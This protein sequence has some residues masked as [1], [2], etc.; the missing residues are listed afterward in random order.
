MNLLNASIR[1][2][3]EIFQ[4]LK[5]ETFNGII[6]I[7]VILLIV[8]YFGWQ[9]PFNKL[10]APQLKSQYN[11]HELKLLAQLFTT[12]SFWIFFILLPIIFLKITNSPRN[13]TFRLEGL[14]L[15][16]KKAWAP[17]ILF[18]IIMVMILA[19]ICS[20][21]SFYRFYPLFRP[22]SLKEWM[23]FEL[24][25][26]PQFIAVEFFFRGPLLFK[27][28]KSIGRSAIALMTLPYAII[29]IHKPFPEAMASVIAG[30][31][32]CHYSLKSKSIW[33]GVILHMLVAVSAD[34]FGLFYGGSFSRW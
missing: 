23:L 21:P 33:P 7:T 15:P 18:G 30:M 32:L 20:Q 8:E 19:A 2:L 10:I 31:V 1:E 17:Y 11:W 27:F 26:L 13:E 22:N 9:G 34:F 4:D 14:S 24:I 6:L 29:H 16:Q 12:T 5:S 25:Y 28:H 3:K